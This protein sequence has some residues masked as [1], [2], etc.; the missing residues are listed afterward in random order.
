MSITREL[1]ES[2][3]DIWRKIFKHPFVIE[4]YRGDLPLEKFKFYI[5]QDYNYL[6]SMYKC[7]SLIAAKSE[8]DIAEKAL[9]IAYLD[10]STEM[11][12]Y[13]KLIGRLGLTM[14]YVLSTEPAPT[15]EAYMN[16]LLKTCAL[17]PPIEG[18]TAILPCF[19]SYMEIAEVNRE[20]LEHNDNELYRS[21]CEVYLLD[22]YK[23]MV[24][25]LKDLVDKYGPGY[26]ID[27]LKHLFK[28][29]SRYEYLFWDMAYN[30]ESWKV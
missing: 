29:G 30:M 28:I 9:E 3:D 23:S 17:E 18:L 24:N 20:L 27:R 22:E 6:V 8:P 11:E 5:I 4:L 13:R 10:A 15:N 7:L 16:F 12:N 14:D 26:D 19:W 2:V 1:R 25:S 21:W